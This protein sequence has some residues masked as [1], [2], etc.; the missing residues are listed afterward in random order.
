MSAIALNGNHI[1]A[2]PPE[3]DAPSKSLSIV[4]LNS[5]K[6]L[7]AGK[8]AADLSRAPR[9]RD[10]DVLMMQ[11]VANEDNKPSV[12]EQLGQTLGYHA[13]FSPAAPGVHDQGLAILSRFPLSN[14]EKR[15]LKYCDLRF[16]CR[17]RYALSADVTTPWGV[18][19]VW[20]VHLDTRVNA[21]ERLEQLQPVIDEATRRGGSSV[22]AGDFNTNEFRWIRNVVPVPGGP[23]HGALIRRAMEA[24][25]FR[26]ALPDD[27]VTFATMKRHLDWIYSRGL[28]PTRWSVE[29]APFSDH[30]AVWTRLVLPG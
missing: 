1:A 8:I 3:R 13:T 2:T 14:I 25:G 4:S 27:V 18:V 20:N 10:A 26:T 22:I 23:K 7:N 19:R 30:H 28:T 21:E 24:R 17:I 6:E 5:A 9:L 12:A 29:P 11:E 15:Q 16:R